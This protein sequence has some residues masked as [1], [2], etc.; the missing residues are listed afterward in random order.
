[1]DPLNGV[2]G[3]AIGKHREKIKL[4]QTQIIHE[5]NKIITG[6]KVLQS[7]LDLFSGV[8][9]DPLECELTLHGPINW[10][11]LLIRMVNEKDAVFHTVIEIIPRFVPNATAVHVCAVFLHFLEQHYDYHYGSYEVQVILHSVQHSKVVPANVFLKGIR[12]WMHNF[13]RENGGKSK[14]AIFDMYENMGYL[15]AAVDPSSP[16]RIDFISAGSV[17]EHSFIRGF[18]SFV[19]KK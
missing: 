4:R 17:W 3:S 2:K 13:S 6:S 7:M 16:S 8:I 18:N 10:G 5:A 19:K 9:P 11:D 1:M 14:L 12:M 15:E